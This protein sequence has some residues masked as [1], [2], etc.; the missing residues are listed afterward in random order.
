MKRSRSTGVLGALLTAMLILAAC[1]SGTTVTAS[2]TPEEAAPDPSPT[3]AEATASPSEDA[4][5]EGDGEVV[6]TVSLAGGQFSPRSISIP[7]GTT[8]TFTDTGG[9][10]V[11]EGSNGTAVED[12]IVDETGGADI[13]VTFEEAGT[14]SITCRIHPG[15]NMTV[16]VQG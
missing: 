10:T 2:A 16:T 4:E 9:H 15:M 1:G 12:P 14:Y 13:E 3:T 7:A 8:V 6:D 5:A 11:T